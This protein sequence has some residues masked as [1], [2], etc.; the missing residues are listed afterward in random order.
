MFIPLSTDAPVYHYPVV[1]IALVVINVAAFLLTGFGGDHHALMTWGLT[2]GEG[3]HP[4]QWVTN[5]FIHGGIIHLVGNMVF[6]WGFGLVVEGKLGWWRFLLVYMGI[7]IAQGAIF[8]TAMLGHDAEQAQI[9]RLE[10][11]G[12]ID[13][14]AEKQ[15]LVELLRDEGFN[16]EEIEEQLKNFNSELLAELGIPKGSVSFGASTAIFGL[17]AIS[18]V[19]APKNEVSVFVFV[20]YRPFVFEMAIMWFAALYIGQDLLIAMW[21]G[22]EMSTP[23]LHA[24]GAI[25]GGIVGVVMFKRGMVDCEDWDIFAVWSGNYGPWARDK[26][27]YRIDPNSENE[28]VNLDEPAEKKRRKKGPS[29]SRRS[30]KLNEVA[31]LVDSGDFVAASDVLHNLRR[32][33]AEAVPDSDVLKNLAVGLARKKLFS[34]AIP[35]MEEFNEWYPEEATGMQLRLAGVHLKQNDRQSAKAVLKTIDR[36][37]LSDGQRETFSKFVEAVRGKYS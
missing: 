2:H 12:F 37:S 21:T 31:E 20:V 6:L 9:E 33:D 35:L 15:E 25:L 32:R 8:Q 7:G 16:D 3:L 36:E 18:L 19:W 30:S 28:T 14:E 5:N 29:R 11:F 22:F 17:L 13:I 34:E 1:C 27:G 23:T 24:T 4:V 10:E 26:Y